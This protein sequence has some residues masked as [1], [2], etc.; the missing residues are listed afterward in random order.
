MVAHR[1]HEWEKTIKTWK[2]NLRYNHDQDYWVKK[3]YLSGEEKSVRAGRVEWW[4]RE[5]TKTEKSRKYIQF[6]VVMIREVEQTWYGTKGGEWWMRRQ[7]SR[8]TT[9]DW[10]KKI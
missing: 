4:A 3:I 1:I 8:V 5:S 6:F 7:S 2:K 9:N 10:E